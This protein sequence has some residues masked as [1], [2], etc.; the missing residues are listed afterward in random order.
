MHLE[1]NHMCVPLSAYVHMP[2]AA[3]A[4]LCQEDCCELLQ[5]WNWI[6]CAVWCISLGA[7]V[8]HSCCRTK[9]LDVG[10]TV[11]LHSAVTELSMCRVCR[12]FVC[13]CVFCLC[14]EV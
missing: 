11:A 2:C 9:A 1:P 8:L 7:V 10:C 14:V 13:V 12:I 3:A 5:A 4:I 6:L